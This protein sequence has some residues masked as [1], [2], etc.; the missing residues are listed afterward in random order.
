VDD[1]LLTAGL[2][3]RHFHNVATIAFD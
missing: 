2:N 1:I 3:N